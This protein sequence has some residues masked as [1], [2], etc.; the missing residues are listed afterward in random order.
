MAPGSVTVAL[1]ND[2]VAYGGGAAAA[3]TLTYYDALAPPTLSA[4]SPAYGPL[5]AGSIVTLYG[6]N[7]VPRGTVAGHAPACVFSGGRRAAGGWSRTLAEATFVSAEEVRCAAPGGAAPETL[8][9][10]LGGTTD[11]GGWALA[12]S[13]ALPYTLR[14]AAVPPAVSSVEP[15]SGGVG[16]G[17]RVTV[18]GRN[19][20]PTGEQSLLC[21]FGALPAAAATFIAEDQLRA[22]CPPPPPRPAARR[23]RLRRRRRCEAPAAPPRATVYRRDAPPELSEVRPNVV[24]VSGGAATLV[25]LGTNLAP[26]AGLRCRLETGGRLL[27]ELPATFLNASAASCD[28]LAPT[29]SLDARLHRRRAAADGPTSAACPLTLYDSSRPPIL[30]DVHPT[31]APLAARRRALSAASETSTSPRVGNVAV[32]AALL[33]PGPSATVVRRRRRPR[34]LRRARRAHGIQR[35]R[36]RATRRAATSR[37]PPSNLR[38][39]TRRARRSSSGAAARDAAGGGDARHY[40]WRTLHLRDALRRVWRRRGARFARERRLPSARRPRR[41]PHEVEVEV[42]GPRARVERALGALGAHDAAPPEATSLVPSL[43]S[44]STYTLRV[45]GDNFS[46]RRHSSPDASSAPLP[47]WRR[48]RLH[49]VPTRGGARRVRSVHE[50]HCTAPP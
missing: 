45:M 24:D 40:Q 47:L 7:F 34:S 2:G 20:A 33:R 17:G 22:P 3:T 43:G 13:G 18:R 26:A 32:T 21:K 6:D 5:A 41:A 10:R 35:S 1:T 37:A 29:S 25:L 8:L 50:L 11:A 44:H 39:S 30:L 15:R 9:V 4:L 38:W 16:G 36:S 46:C 28:M 14:D 42:S 27:R 12:E 48:R 31:F 23:R 49:V 19:F